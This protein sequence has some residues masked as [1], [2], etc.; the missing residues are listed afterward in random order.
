[1]YRKIFSTE[2]L[3]FGHKLTAP[4]F[5]LWGYLKSKVYI[6]KPQT[7]CVR[8]KKTAFDVKLLQYSAETL[9][10]VMQN[11]EKRAHCAIRENRGK[12]ILK[13]RNEYFWSCE[14]KELRF[15]SHGSQQIF[16]RNE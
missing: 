3:L 9:Q 4:D 13:E 16:N 15:G 2:D 12:K 5:F 1:M 7:L 10:N 6:K 8:K 11:A 14:S